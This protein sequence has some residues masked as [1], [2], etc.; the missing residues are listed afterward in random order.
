MF[1]ACASMP[2]SAEN[3]YLVNKIAFLHGLFFAMIGKD[4][5]TIYKIIL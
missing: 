5:F 3:S 1:A 2:A 4:T